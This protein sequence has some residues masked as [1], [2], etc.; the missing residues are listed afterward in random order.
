MLDRS[1]R[2]DLQ[3]QALLDGTVDL[4]ARF[5]SGPDLRRARPHLRIARGKVAGEPHLA[6]SRLTTHSVAA[7]ADRGLSAGRITQLYPHEDRIAL[8]EALDLER[9]LPA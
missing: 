3:G 6:H 1:P 7:L 2:E 8:H 5:Q 9:Q 4:F